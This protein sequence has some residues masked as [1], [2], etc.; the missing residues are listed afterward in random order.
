[1]QQAALTE[2]VRAAAKFKGY[3][4]VKFHGGY[5]LEREDD[6][7]REIIVASTLELIV[8]FLKH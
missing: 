2:E 3:D 4:L 5:Q 1:M 7:D 8:D 6:Y